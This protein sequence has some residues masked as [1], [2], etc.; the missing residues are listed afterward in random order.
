MKK[1]ILLLS[2]TF[3][4]ISVYGQTRENKYSL[5]ADST[6]ASICI[7]YIQGGPFTMGS[8]NSEARSNE[9]PHTVT[10]GNFAMMKHLVTVSDFKQFVDAT[11]Y[12]TDADKR[13][14]GYGSHILTVSGGK[15]EDGVNWKCGVS[16]SPRPLSEYNHPVIHVS[17]ND[18]VA[19]AEW[20]SRKTGMKWRLPSEAEWE[21]AARAGQ[22]YKYAGSDN[23]GNVGWYNDNSGQNTHAVGQKSPNNFGL[24]DMTGN[25]WEWCSDWFGS[26]YYKSSPPNNPQ[27]PSSGSGRVLRGGSWGH[28]AQY[29]RT[30]HRHNR[31]PDARNYYNSFRLVLVD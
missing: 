13:T 22:N 2:I 18:A 25:V 10:V 7:R 11:D 1:L 12:Q 17:W 9:T 3:L 28:F 4:T 16:G 31:R 26:D 24:Y 29:C 19:Y 20:L 23:I 30:T 5:N 8:N 21:Y 15:K 14:R 6:I 27:G